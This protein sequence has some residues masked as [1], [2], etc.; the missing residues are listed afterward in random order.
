M[1]IHTSAQRIRTALLAP[2]VSA[3][4]FICAGAASA[5]TIDPNPIL[6]DDSSSGVSGSITLV[7]SGD[8]VPSGGDVLVGSVD[9]SDVTMAFEI[10]LDQ[11]SSAVNGVSVSAFNPDTFSGPTLAGGGDV[12]NGGED[13][14]GASTSGS[15]GVLYE[16]LDD[17][18]TSSNEELEGQETS[19]RFFISYESLTT[20]GSLDANFMISP[21][22]GSR[23][24][25]AN[26]AIVPEPATLAL[27]GFGVG[28]LALLS[29]RR[30]G[31]RV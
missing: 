15:N 8:G 16:F 1:L 27:I 7:D 3:A 5:L 14:T 22:D 28:G 25:D 30:R 18:G 29:G 10:Q 21:A 11:G 17:E 26:A 19:D 12:P 20:D 4:L 31:R 23:D 6:F 13:I 9:G 2:A 24:F